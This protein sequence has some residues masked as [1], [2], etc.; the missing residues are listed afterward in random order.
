M[1]FGRHFLKKSILLV[2]IF[3]PFTLMASEPVNGY[4]DAKN[5]WIVFEWETPDNGLQRSIL[6]SG[7]KVK[8]AIKSAVSYDQAAQVFTYTF[9]I[10]NLQGAVQAIKGI[11]VY[12]PAPVSNATNPS[13]AEEWSG[14]EYRKQGIWYWS[15]DR[16]SIHG[17]PAGQTVSGFSFKSSGLPTI[18]DAKFSGRARNRYFVPGDDDSPSVDQSFDRI[19][20]Q[21]KAQY[22]NSF[23][24]TVSLKTLGPVNPPATFDA[25]GSIRN[26]ITLVNQSR[27]QGW[28]DNDGIANSLTAKLNTALS[29][30]TSDP[31]T[32]KNVLG[33]FLNDVQAQNGKHLSSEA[34]ALLYFNGQYVVTH[35]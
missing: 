20:S 22:P 13:P 1:K 21:L 26:L 3:T 18:V 30:A 28:I 5:N 14:N 25:A 4:Y 2:S 11:Y 32:A 17:I 12:H 35:M 9:T 33:A 31:K 16:G 8:P 34:Y 19:Y 10:S 24:D 27:A 15:K 6:D 23:I 29:K 7:N